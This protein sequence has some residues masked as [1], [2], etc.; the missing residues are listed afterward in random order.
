[1]PNDIGNP[2]DTIF[3]VSSSPALSHSLSTSRGSSILLFS[4]L[5]SFKLL[6]K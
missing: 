5:E 2:I 4:S 3:V 6:N 1:L